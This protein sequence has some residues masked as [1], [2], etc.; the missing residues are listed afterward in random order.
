MPHP[1]SGELCELANA[2][3]TAGVLAIVTIDD[4]AQEWCDLTAAGMSRPDSDE[5]TEPG[6]EWWPIWFSFNCLDEVPDLHRELLVKLV[7]AAPNDEVLGAIGAGP[8]ED[9]LYSS[10]DE[11]HWLEAEASK[12]A[13]FER[14]LDNMRY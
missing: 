11:I 4:I 12:D 9:W 1:R 3:D 2:G 10:P 13:R 6:P 14:A 5:Q 8:F 7:A